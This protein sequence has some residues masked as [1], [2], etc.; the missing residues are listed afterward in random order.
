MFGNAGLKVK[1]GSCMAD[2]ELAGD[3]Q[4]H[5]F[6]RDGTGKS[7]TAIWRK[8]QALSFGGGYESFEGKRTDLQ[9]KS[10]NGLPILG[11]RL[12]RT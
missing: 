7:F 10:S 1:N 8:H 3:Q 4:R 12:H 5:L 9:R 11:F 6:F 2:G